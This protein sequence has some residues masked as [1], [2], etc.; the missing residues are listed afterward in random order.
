MMEVEKNVLSGDKTSLNLPP[1]LSMGQ[2]M[3][4]R[5]ST[6]GDRVA[7]VIILS[8]TLV[9]Y[10]FHTCSLINSL[11]LQNSVFELFQP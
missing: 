7:S 5:L 4:D 11:C 8:H 10:H 3:L 9:S 1:D 2:F 6:F